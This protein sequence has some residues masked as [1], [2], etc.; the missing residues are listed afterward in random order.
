MNE[1]VRINKLKPDIKRAFT[2]QR[3]V[4]RIEKCWQQTIKSINIIK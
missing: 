4:L 2:M 3:S 1:I